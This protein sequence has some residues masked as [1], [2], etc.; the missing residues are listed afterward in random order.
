MDKTTKLCI[1]CGGTGE[2][3]EAQDIIPAMVPPEPKATECK[4]CS[5]TGEEPSAD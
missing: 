5:G 3:Y 1:A 2:Q 4:R